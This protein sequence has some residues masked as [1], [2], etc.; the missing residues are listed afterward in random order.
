M[1]FG[2]MWETNS[3]LLDESPLF[4]PSVHP[5]L[6][7]ASY[8][9]SPDFFLCSPHTFYNHQGSPPINK[10]KYESCILH[11]LN[12]RP[13]NLL[14]WRGRA[15]LERIFIKH[16][17]CLRSQH[18]GRTNSLETLFHTEAHLST[19]GQFL[20]R[21]STNFRNASFAKLNLSEAFFPK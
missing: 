3:H 14:F 7:S 2:F 18:G 1:T 11:W 12:I 10:R 4:E 19:Q 13:I 5:P 17:Q 15:D 16:I 6:P 20:E 9:T 8:T 21:V